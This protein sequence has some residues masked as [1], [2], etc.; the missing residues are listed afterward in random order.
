[1]NVEEIIDKKPHL[2]DSL[3]LYNKISEFNKIVSI[4]EKNP[5]GFGDA[6]YP[7]DL[8]NQIFEGFSS[9]LD[10]PM[11]HLAPLKEAMDLG[12]I[13]LSRLPLNETP[14]F[15]LPY[16]EDEMFKILFLISRPYFLWL[17]IACNLNNTFWNE[18]KCPVCNSIP[19]LSS[20]KKGE[21]RILYCSYCE[22][23]GHWHR[24][25]CPNCLTENFKDISIVILEG[26]EG[27]RADKCEKCKIYY[28]SFERYLTTGYSLDILDII[29]LPLDIVLQKNGYMRCSPNPLGM[30]R[31]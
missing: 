17:N 22:C 20:I 9:T 19:S 12:Q 8:I 18:G 25:A 4:V 29:S 15:T 28:K 16:H 26:E 21:E 7:P 24:I 2:G 11:D 1:M 6:T 23:S 27:I 10:I 3:R 13:D 14:A 30:I 31:I 5:I